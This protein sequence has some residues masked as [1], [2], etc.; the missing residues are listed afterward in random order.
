MEHGVGDNVGSQR[1]T[2][3]GVIEAI[4]REAGLELF[5]LEAPPSGR[6]TLRVFIWRPHDENS[7]LKGVGIEDCVRISKRITN[8]ENVDEVLPGDWLIEVSSPGVNRKLSRPEHF[9]G[10]VGER[11]KLT[12]AAGG[13]N[14]VLKGVLCAFD[15]SVVE[16]EVEGENPKDPA[17]R[18]AV[19][20]GEI[21][22]ARV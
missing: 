22:Q 5:D 7:P 17:V 6:G 14:E 1:E 12:V 16:I 4:V 20:F 8:L 21:N 3:W 19:P 2:L 15:G 10:A 13:R 11:I 18:R 9:A